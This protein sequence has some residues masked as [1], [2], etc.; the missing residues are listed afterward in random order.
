MTGTFGP[1]QRDFRLTVPS[2]VTSWAQQSVAE[3]SVPVSQRASVSDHSGIQD[4]SQRGSL[5][6]GGSG[7]AW[8]NSLSNREAFSNLTT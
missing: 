2:I 5:E 7:R 8:L 4:E 3:I 6:S 1:N